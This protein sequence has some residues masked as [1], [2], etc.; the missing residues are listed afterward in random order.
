MDILRLF[1]VFDKIA[2]LEQMRIRSIPFPK[3]NVGGSFESFD[4]K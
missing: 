4:L 3:L 2:G 1:M